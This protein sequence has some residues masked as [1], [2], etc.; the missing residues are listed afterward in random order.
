MPMNSRMRADGHDVGPCFF[1]LNAGAGGI[2]RRLMTARQCAK[3]GA[4]IP[5][6]SPVCRSCFEPVER[7]GIL[8]RLLRFLCARISVGKSAAGATQVRLVTRTREQFK[9]RDR[10]TGELRVYE[11]L[12]EVPLE[13]REKVRQAWQAA[14]S[15]KNIAPIVVRDGFGKEQIYHSPEE[16]PP[17]LR[18]LYEKAI[19]K[20]S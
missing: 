14:L 10:Q 17:E 12:E 7:E 2:I 20:G 16:L 1:F 3:C 8:S 11:S 9:I 15:G 6:G 13:H 5:E 19:N 18:A 4:E